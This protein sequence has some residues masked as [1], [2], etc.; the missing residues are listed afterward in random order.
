MDLRPRIPKVCCLEDGSV[1][2]VVKTVQ[3]SLVEG[4]LVSD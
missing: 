1:T 2:L 4:K 3:K